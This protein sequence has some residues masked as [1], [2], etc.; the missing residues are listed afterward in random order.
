MQ[1]ALHLFQAGGHAFNMGLRKEQASLKGWP[2]LLVNW[3]A[4]NGW[5]K[6]R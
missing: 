1:Q 3:L 4:D 2:N 6:P 5:L